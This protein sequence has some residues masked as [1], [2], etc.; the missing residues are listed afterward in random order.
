[1]EGLGELAGALPHPPR[2]LDLPVELRLKCLASCDWKTLSVAACANRGTRAL[3]EYLVRAPYWRTHSE[4]QPAV[5][6]TDFASSEERQQACDNWA[7]E[8]TAKLCGHGKPDLCL[9]FVSPRSHGNLPVMLRALRAHLAACTLLAGM[10]APGVLGRDTASKEVQELDAAEHAGLV[11]SVAHLPPG[12]QVQ[13]AFMREG[14]PPKRLEGHHHQKQQQQWQEQLEAGHRTGEDGPDL[15]GELPSGLATY[16]RTWLVLSDRHADIDGVLQ[17]LGQRYPGETLCGGMGGGT[18]GSPA[19]LVGL[20]GRGPDDALHAEVVSGTLAIAISGPGVESAPVSARGMRC[21]S[22]RFMVTQVA[23]NVEMAPVGRVTLVQQMQHS[24]PLATKAD[25]LSWV[26]VGAGFTPTSALVAALQ[27][28]GANVAPR[29]PLFFGVRRPGGKRLPGPEEN[30]MV[31]LQMHDPNN[32]MRT[33]GFVSVQ[34]AV[35]QGMVAAFH[36]PQPA[37]SHAQLQAQL[38]ELSD[39]CFYREHAEGEQS[40]DEG[41][42]PCKSLDKVHQMLDSN[43]AP[44]YGCLLFPCVAKGRRYYGTPNVESDM[45]AAAYPSAAMAG[46]FCNGEIGPVPPDEL[47]PSDGTTARMMGYSTVMCMLKLTPGSPPPPEWVDS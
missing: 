18:D 32:L 39:T 19:L 8:L 26:P 7:K 45:V 47:A 25:S 43:P 35:E 3:V 20:P 16:P 12:S 9:V 1:M 4:Q 22:Q 46:F 27:A 23:A 36:T 41:R 11:V 37:L 24:M 6:T 10:V 38:K 28:Q 29:A 2:F 13:A 31:M 33:S 5:L 17:E 44:V 42:E 14:L 21:I 40:A 15:E 30:R 34:F